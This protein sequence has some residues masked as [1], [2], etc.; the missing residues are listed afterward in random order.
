VAARLVLWDI[1]GTL[2]RAGEIAREAFG[3]AVASVVERADHEIEFVQMSGKTDLQIAREMLLLAAVE[4]AAA[5]DHVPAVI[6]HLEAEL[7]AAE[8]MFRENGRVLPGV[9]ELL[10]AFGEDPAVHQSLLTGNTAS[11]AKAKVDAFCLTRHFD[12]EIGA[13]GSDH[14]D[15]TKLVPI[16][17]ERAH[18]LRD[19]T[20]DPSDVWIIGDSPNDFFCARAG[21]THCL[22]V[23][24]GRPTYDELAQLG[25]DAV[26]RDLSDVE[27]VLEVVCA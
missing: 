20:F 9:V 6:A 24:T 14:A 1:D 4:D 22:L 2:L 21:G 19:L 8:A 13:F 5:D 27:R 7:G 12:L 26:F 17:L 15:R 18:R 16:A 10:E 11:N 25:A 23:A 3:R